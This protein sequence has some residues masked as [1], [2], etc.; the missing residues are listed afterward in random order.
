MN[1]LTGGGPE[2]ELAQSNKGRTPGLETEVVS[3]NTEQEGV[4]EE[5]NK[6]N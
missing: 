4:K 1:W 6:I 3:G 2:A 5:E